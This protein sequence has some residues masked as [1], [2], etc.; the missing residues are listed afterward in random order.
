MSYRPRRE[1]EEDPGYKQL[2]P[3]VIFRH[4]RAG[5][6]TLFAYTRGSGQGEGRLHRKRSVGIGGHISAD[7]AA[8]P[9]ANVYEEGLR[10][11]LREEVII[12]TAVRESCV[13]LINDD[14]TPVG[15]VHLGVVHIFDVET[16]AVQPRLATPVTAS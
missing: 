2:I 13:G 11:E 7:D 8:M 3:Y 15:Q 12:D 5:Q 10:R 16:P 1:V 4:F 14:E 9:G 6:T